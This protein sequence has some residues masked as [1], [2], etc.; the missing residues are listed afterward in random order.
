M[1]EKPFFRQKILFLLIAAFFVQI[2]FVYLVL[3]FN[4]YETAKQE[5]IT[6]NEL[7]VKNEANYVE[8]L[9]YLGI[10][11]A[12][13]ISKNT[14]ISS[15]LG[16]NAQPLDE[17]SLYF[18][19][20]FRNNYITSYSN[21]MAK[22][23]EYSD[24]KNPVK[25]EVFS[26]NPNLLYSDF[27]K[28][29][30][31][32]DEETRLLAL[33]SEFSLMD[34]DDISLIKS[35]FFDWMEQPTVIRIVFSKQTFSREYDRNLIKSGNLLLKTKQKEYP[36]NPFVNIKGTPL[37]CETEI[38]VP[39]YPFARCA[40]HYSYDQRNVRSAIMPDILIITVIFAVIIVAVIFIIVYLTKYLTNSLYLLIKNIN[41]AD[42][43]E[44]DD[45][46]PKKKNE[47]E[48]IRQKLIALS[49]EIKQ[50]ESEVHRNE[51]LKKNAEAK[52][53]QELFK[54][55]FLYN[56]LACLKYKFKGNKVLVSVVN[57]M[58]NYYRV[59]LNRSQLE[60]PIEKELSM[61]ESYLSIQNFC[62]QKEVALTVDIDKELK[63]NTISK[64]I[65]QPFV[66]NAFIHGFAEME[67]GC[68]ISI[69]AQKSGDNIC[70]E[71]RDNG[72]GMSREKINEILSL[73]KQIDDFGVNHYGIYNTVMRLK[74]YY[75][76]SHTIQ[77]ESTVGKGTAL[78]FTVPL[79]ITNR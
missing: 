17:E 26:P 28:P 36:L 22:L 47:F 51:I 53:L 27:L 21:E 78:R 48:I 24:S 45:S 54:P 49:D 37:N 13:D 61:I 10:I 46:S 38:T 2:V 20:M 67:N 43:L 71:I 59:A 33:Q 39:N 1:T 50:K 41:H 60:I 29:Y 66:E 62:Y 25:I 15:Y 65:I 64:L 6:L 70:F 75:G 8:K 68:E 57:E 3:I 23:S 74:T 55:H 35:V 30:S 40:L 18:Y 73:S 56:T 79:Q 52:L 58:V 69:S 19:A 42:L 31:A 11:T 5:Q 77:I 76:E 72:C 34:N 9:L 44:A 12:N 32:L 16:L 7:F 14:A 63:N 4:R